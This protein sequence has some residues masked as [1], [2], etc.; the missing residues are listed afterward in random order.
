M[1]VAIPELESEPVSEQRTSGIH[2]VEGLWYVVPP[3][4]LF[5]GL[6][7]HQRPL[8]LEFSTSSA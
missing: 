8:H 1:V 4:R 5:R 6:R 7:V 3:P 2:R